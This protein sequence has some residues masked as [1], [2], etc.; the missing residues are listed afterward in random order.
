[1]QVMRDFMEEMLGSNTES[2]IYTLIVVVS[3][4]GLI[5]IYFSY[6]ILSELKEMKQSMNR[7]E[8]LLESVE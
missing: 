5:S 1:M 3:I 2:S 4:L 7:V 6:T 8:K